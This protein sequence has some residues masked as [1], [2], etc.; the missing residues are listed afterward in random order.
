M[1]S[2]RTY[3][4]GE[5]SISLH[6]S[7]DVYELLAVPRRAA[8]VGVLAGR[9]A[10][11][12]GSQVANGFHT[13]TPAQPDVIDSDGSNHPSEP[14]EAYPPF[15]TETLARHVAAREAE[16]DP[17]SVSDAEHRSVHVSLVHNHLPKLAANGIVEFEPEKDTVRLADDAPVTSFASDAELGDPTVGRWTGHV[18][19]RSQPRRRLA[20]SI[21]TAADGDVTVDELARELA[22]REKQADVSDVDERTVDR[23]RVS[24][25]HSHLPALSSIG[26]VEFDPD[27]RAV[28]N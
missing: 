7:G 6:A 18:R 13:D 2:K 4:A 10:P 20:V 3:P 19:T 1:Q 28:S 14:G 5:V 21:V 22:A 26:L 8:L 12:A 9:D 11:G 27:E 25:Y 15:D 23:V 24:L 16:K 17:E